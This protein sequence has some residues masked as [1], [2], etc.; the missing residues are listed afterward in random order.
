MSSAWAEVLYRKIKINYEYSYRHKVTG[1]SESNPAPVY[2]GILADVSLS[3]SV[4]LSNRSLTGCLG[5]GPWEDI[6]HPCLDMFLCG[7]IAFTGSSATGFFTPGDSH[8]R[9]KI[10]YVLPRQR[11]CLIT[12]HQQLYL[13]GK[14]RL[15]GLTISVDKV[16]ISNFF[17]FFQAHFSR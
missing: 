1:V 2:G 14:N 3:S 15:K 7:R 10:K 17:F 13:G 5:H 12:D 11:R 16:L 6:E 9:S 8:C 4:P